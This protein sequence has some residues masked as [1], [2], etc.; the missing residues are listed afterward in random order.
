MLKEILESKPQKHISSGKFS[1]SSIGG[2]WR[3]KFSELKGIYKE[4]YDEKM[5]RIFAQGDFFHQRMISELVSKGPSQGYQVAAAE[6]DIRDNEYIS[7]R[8]DCI[9]SH[10][11]S[12]EL[13]IIDFKSCSPWAF[14]NVQNGDVSQTYQDQVLLYE[15]IFHIPRG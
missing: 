15:Y 5:F 4:E 12:K 2:C 11:A 9:L 7:G 8:C 13:F 14:K 3:K 6:C 1:I 10:S